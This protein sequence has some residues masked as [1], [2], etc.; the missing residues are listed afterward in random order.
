MDNYYKIGILLVVICIAVYFFIYSSNSQDA[1]DVKTEAAISKDMP[2]NTDTLTAAA[3][4]ADDPNKPIFDSAEIKNSDTPPPVNPVVISANSNANVKC[5]DGTYDNGTQCAYDRGAGV[6]RGCPIN[7]VQR[8]VECYE[9]PE[10]GYDWTTKDGLLIGKICPDGVLDNGSTCHYDRG[11]G[12]P[13]QCPAGLVKNGS[14]CYEPLPKGYDW[15][16]GALGSYAR[17]CPEGTASLAGT[18]SYDRGIGTPMQCPAGK[19]KNGSLCYDPLPAGYDWIDGIVGSYAKICPSG[20]TSL[21]ATCSYDRDST[22]SYPQ[23]K[24]DD[25]NDPQVKSGS[26]C[27]KQCK[28][29]TDDP[30]KNSC[31]PHK[32]AQFDYEWTATGTIGLKCPAGTNT[33]AA[34]CSYDRGV[35]KEPICGP[36]KVKR[37]IECYEQPESGYDWT[38][39][40]GLLVGKICPSGTLDN[41]STCT[42]TRAAGIIP[43]K[44]E[45]PAGTTD[46]GT[47]CRKDLIPRK[48]IGAVRVKPCSDWNSRYRDDG[49]SC[50]LDIKNRTGRAPDKAACPSGSTDIGTDCWMYGYDRGVGRIPDKQGC[51]DFGNYRDDG[52]SCWDDSLLK[53]H[54]KTI[55][56]CVYWGLGNWTPCLGKTECSGARIVKTAMDRYRCNS[57]EELYASMCYK[58]CRPGYH[59]TTATFCEANI[60]RVKTLADRF[61]CQGHEDLALSMCYPKC[62]DEYTW[63][64]SVPGTCVPKDGAG[65]KVNLE[66]RYTC[67]RG[68]K[69]GLLCYE[70]CPAGYHVD[71]TG[72]SCIPDDGIGVKKSLSD[73]IFCPN[74]KRFEDSKTLCYDSP[75]DGFECNAQICSMN[76]HVKPG[77]MVGYAKNCEN[78]TDE[79]DGLLCYSKRKEL[80][81]KDGKNKLKF[82]CDVTSCRLDRN[83]TILNPLG[84]PKTCPKGKEMVGALCYDEPK[85]GFKCDVTSCYMG[86]DNKIANPLQIPNICGDDKVLENALCYAKPKKYK[87]PDGNEKDFKCNITSCL[88][89]RDNK[90]ANPKQV[91]D[92]CGSDKVKQNALCYKKPRDGFSC[93]TTVCS[94][95]KQIKPG[96]FI[97]LIQ[98]CPDDKKSLEDTLC[99]KAP[100]KGFKCTATFCSK[101]YYA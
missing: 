94:Q 2:A 10:D 20:T 17:I 18:C 39:A 61:Y 32:D 14:L 67:D 96:K 92:Q 81:S 71:S 75:R 69:V 5:P 95:S 21:A 33:L 89:D 16:D 35:G 43:W 55:Q 36:G 59:T 31:F 22:K 23:C 40:G 84:V 50:W 26:L 48:I 13:M 49:T 65:V 51:R 41:G 8:G 62:G 44:S 60:N 88:I 90:I 58:K 37:G 42:Y 86:R 74:G 47:D 54:T 27:Y 63:N 25:P 46:T 19:V 77:K 56:K 29:P 72:L 80:I 93:D 34:T 64:D 45:C 12:T 85:D 68:T 83:I 78:T 30:N 98:S 100:K 82:T 52:T 4:A 3:A 7:S 57:D 24:T 6:F 1:K 53:C 9:K 11:I 97:G 66:D 15:I 38:T 91:P 70:D 28:N 76:K 99:Y 87:D 79:F 73:R 101:P